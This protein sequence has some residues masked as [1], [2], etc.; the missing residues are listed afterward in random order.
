[1]Q[2]ANGPLKGT[3]FN[4]IPTGTLNENESVKAG[5]E[6]ELLEETAIK[7]EFLG[8]IGFRHAVNCSWTFGKSDLFFICLLKPLSTDIVK[9]DSEI[10]HAGWLDLDEYYSQKFPRASQSYD[11]M[12]EIIKEA[13]QQYLKDGSVNNIVNVVT[14]PSGWRSG[15]EEI[16]YVPK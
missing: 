16:F 4:K 9:Q 5:I 12:Q 11:K 7:C 10:S 14:L 13:V 6:R 3:K 2:E 8:V 1:M 15:F